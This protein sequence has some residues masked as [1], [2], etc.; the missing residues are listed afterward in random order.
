M[1]VGSEIILNQETW[2]FA[3]TIEQFDAHILQSI[4]NCQEQ[5]AYIASLARFFLFSGARVYE[6]GVST[7]AL[8]ESVLARMPE[9]PIEYIGL[10]IEA[11]MVEKA[12][13]RLEHE[14][15]FQALQAQVEN[16]AYQPAQ[17]VISYYTLQ[18]I[19]LAE[20]KKLLKQLFQTLHPGGALIL[21]EKTLGENALIQDMLTQ[22]YYDFKADQGL[23][24]DAILNKAIALRGVSMPLSLEQNRNLLLDA[25]FSQVE[26]IYRAYCFAGYLAVKDSNVKSSFE[27]EFKPIGPVPTL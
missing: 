23:S 26:I 20:R 13:Q 17:C 25:G 12:R 6:I 27:S 22:L 19:P 24:S 16:F 5:R 2:S 15:R 11:S 9:R 18:F 3:D 21:Y 10:D 4:P 14:P 1:D 8:A 7:G